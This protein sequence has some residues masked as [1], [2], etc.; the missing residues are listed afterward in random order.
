MI[1]HTSK[2]NTEPALSWGLQTPDHHHQ[3]KSGL[4]NSHGALVLLFCRLR[5][6]SVHRVGYWEM[7]S[8]K[9]ITKT[10][11][12]VPFENTLIYHLRQ[13]WWFQNSQTV[14]C[15]SGKSIIVKLLLPF[16]EMGTRFY[17]IGLLLL[18]LMNLYESSILMLQLLKLK[19]I[20]T[21]LNGV[22]FFI[23]DI[24]LNKCWKNKW[25]MLPALLMFYSDQCDSDWLAS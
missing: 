7:M 13:T 2:K 23:H 21:T 6:C 20:L 25:H 4:W 8:E 15:T 1:A 11:L 16:S 9:K 24:K 19:L 17:I 3:G 14:K 12:L 18:F 5:T 10:A 22:V